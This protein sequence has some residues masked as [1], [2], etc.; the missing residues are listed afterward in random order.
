MTLF[1]YVILLEALQVAW[2]EVYRGSAGCGRFS[3]A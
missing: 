1:H 3:T 2:F